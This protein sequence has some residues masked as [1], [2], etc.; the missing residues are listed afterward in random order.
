MEYCDSCR[1][2]LNER[3]LLEEQLARVQNKLEIVA[4]QLKLLREENELLKNAKTIGR[5]PRLNNARRRFKN[6]K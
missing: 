2:V 4:T 3:H 5:G 6:C 1:A